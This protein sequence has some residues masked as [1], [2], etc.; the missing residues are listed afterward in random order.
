M[1]KN[2]TKDLKRRQRRIGLMASLFRRAQV[3]GEALKQFGNQRLPHRILGECITDN[4]AKN[5]SRNIFDQRKG[6]LGISGVTDSGGLLLENPSIVDMEGERRMSESQTPEKMI[7]VKPNEQDSGRMDKLRNS[8]ANVKSDINSLNNELAGLNKEVI[9]QQG[10]LNFIA[11]CYLEEHEGYKIIDWDAKKG[12][13]ILVTDPNAPQPKQ[14]K[15]KAKK[16]TKGTKS[17][18]A[19]VANG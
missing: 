2:R 7:R 5:E 10:A 19:E 15:A 16:K 13:L 11:G 3:F 12:E 9:A 1:K 17:I 14:E 8:I 6:D 4:L 18:P